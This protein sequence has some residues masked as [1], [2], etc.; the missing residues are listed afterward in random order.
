MFKKCPSLLAK[1]T[2]LR[3]GH[4]RG[5]FTQNNEAVYTLRH[6]VGDSNCWE[7]GH[8]KNKYLCIY[9]KLRKTI[10]SIKSQ[11]PWRWDSIA[12]CYIPFFNLVLVLQGNHFTYIYE[13]VASCLFTPIKLYSPRQNMGTSEFFPNESVSTFRQDFCYITREAQI[14]L[15]ISCSY[16]TWVMELWAIVA[17]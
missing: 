7:E 4:K 2:S 12:R 8:G 16:T 11:L 14:Y 3:G 10:Y 1:N 17:T 6:N 13:R 5:V 9:D 15:R